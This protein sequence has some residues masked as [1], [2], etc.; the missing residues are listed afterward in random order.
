MRSTLFANFPLIFLQIRG[1][2]QTLAQMGNHIVILLIIKLPF[3]DLY[4]SSYSHAVSSHQ[5]IIDLWSLY[6]FFLHPFCSTGSLSFTSGKFQIL[7]AIGP[8]VLT[9]VNLFED[10]LIMILLTLPLLLLLQLINNII[11]EISST[12]FI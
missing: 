1:C 5:L 9:N 11:T 7:S 2:C 4:I 6:F 10:V 3:P 12:F 8:T